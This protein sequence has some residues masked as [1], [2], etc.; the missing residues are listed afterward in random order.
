MW[1]QAKVMIRELLMKTGLK[2]I[3]HQEHRKLLEGIDYLYRNYVFKDLSDSEERRFAR[4]AELMGTGVHEAYHLIHHLTKCLPLEGDVCEFGVAQGATSALIAG[5]IAETDKHLWLFDSFEGLPKPTAKDRLIDD[6]FNL[7]D[8]AKYEGEMA[9]S[10]RLVKNKLKAVGFDFSRAHIVPGFVEN[11]LKSA[12]LPPEICF[13]YVDFDFYEPTC[14]VLKTFDTRLASGG[15]FFVDD[16]DYFSSGIKT[17]VEEF[18]DESPKGRYELFVPP[19]ELGHF[20]V[21][22]KS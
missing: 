15:V 20:C 10:V 4:L 12:R 21:L 9:N 2:V 8:M 11:T 17:A 13:A 16:Y 7:G 22:T 6:I 14:E 18:L 19:A 1:S 5:E 3:K